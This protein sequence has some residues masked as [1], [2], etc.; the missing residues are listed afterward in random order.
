MNE[1]KKVKK[2]SMER[3]RERKSEREKGILK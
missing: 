3:E 2:V 1:Q